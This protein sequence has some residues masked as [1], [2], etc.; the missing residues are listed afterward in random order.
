MLGMAIHGYRLSKD[1]KNEVYTF[2]HWDRSFE[3]NSPLK[4][5][6]LIATL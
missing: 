6:M 2:I 3:E 1:K 5:N 4:Q